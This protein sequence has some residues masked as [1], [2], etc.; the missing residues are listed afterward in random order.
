MTTYSWTGP[1]GF[2]SAVQSPTISAVTAAAAGTYTLTVTNSN[3][4]TASTTVVVTINP[5]PVPTAGSNSPICAGF[6]LN[7]TGNPSG[8]TS[9]SW[10][11]PN[12][13]ASTTQSP[14]I[15]NALVAASGTYTLTVTN[16]NGCNGS[17][18][19]TVVVNPK[20][21]TTPITHN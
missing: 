2:T 9:Y 15:S 20:P 3:G 4:C 5:L 10:T 18:T 12:G 16:S 6:T 17:A 1:N 7:L 13:F 14:S 11:G 8:M 19:T 21:A